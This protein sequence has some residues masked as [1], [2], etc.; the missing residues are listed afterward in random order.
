MSTKRPN[1]IL[2]PA[3][4]AAFKSIPAEDVHYLTKVGL[5]SCGQDF[6]TIPPKA[7]VVDWC[8]VEHIALAEDGPTL[9]CLG[10]RGVVA[11]EAEGT[12]FANE[13]IAQLSRMIEIYAEYRELVRTLSDEEAEQWVLRIAQR[14]TECDQR[15]LS[16]PESYWSV[17]LEQMEYG[18]L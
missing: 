15:A 4:T 9:L 1:R 13:S 16:D 12:R 3:A 6:L 14:M 5:P 2:W 8:P 17:I 10:P 11:I 7:D 18:H